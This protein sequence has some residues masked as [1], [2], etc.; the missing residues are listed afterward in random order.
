MAHHIPK[1]EYGVHW[2]FFMTLAFLKVINLFILPF[3]STCCLS[4]IATVLV[5][6]YEL[7][8]NFGLADWIMGDAP[9]DTLFSANR[10][11]IL[12]LIG[13][14]AIFLYSLSMKSRLSIFMNKN[15]LINYFY[16]GNRVVCKFVS[17]ICFCAIEEYCNNYYYLIK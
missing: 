2:N 3:V 13:Y 16:K 14:E 1:F 9:R 6:I 7:A 12:S 10:E 15:H 4:G 11:G 5:I 8:L 17:L